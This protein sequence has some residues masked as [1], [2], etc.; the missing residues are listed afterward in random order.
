MSGKDSP[1]DEG[2]GVSRHILHPCNSAQSAYIPSLCHMYGMFMKLSV[3]V[4][5][6]GGGEYVWN[7]CGIVME[8]LLNM[9]GSRN[10]H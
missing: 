7:T 1:G 9:Y 2:A 4:C 10:F 6:W 5:V 3:C 8:Y